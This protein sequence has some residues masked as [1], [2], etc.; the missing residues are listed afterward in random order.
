MILIAFALMMLNTPP[1]C[2]P[3]SDVTMILFNPTSCICVDH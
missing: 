1:D 2:I 3:A